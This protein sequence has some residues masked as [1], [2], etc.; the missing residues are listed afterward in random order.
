[1][2]KLIIGALV[3]AIFL[4]VWQF[5]S[6]SFM[7]TS[8]LQYTAEQD[9]ILECLD[10]KLQPG[11]YFLPTV[12]AGTSFEEHEK[13]IEPY[14]GG[15]WAQINYRNDLSMSM[16]SN[17]LRGFVVDFVAVFLL[18]WLFGKI[19]DLDMKTAVLGSIAVGVIG[20]LTIN[21]L[22][23]IWF[24]T[25]SIPDLIDAIVPWALTGAWLGWWLNR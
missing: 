21:Y 24:E 13:L 17:M 9:A 22:N 6:W 25:N 4:F 16:G 3:G 18:C 10:G 14:I 23:S 12:P 7:R 11:Q 8:Q 5:V 2:K 20:Y 1:M 15:N 19:A